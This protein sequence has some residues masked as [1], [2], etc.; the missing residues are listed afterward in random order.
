M[1]VVNQHNDVFARS[2]SELSE[3]L[4]NLQHL[5]LDVTAK[6]AELEKKNAALCEKHTEELKAFKEELMADYESRLNGHLKSVSGSAKAEVA[7]SFDVALANLR[8][9]IEQIVTETIAR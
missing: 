7:A 8:N 4:E 5:C 3:K 2:L 9:T 6:N 1:P